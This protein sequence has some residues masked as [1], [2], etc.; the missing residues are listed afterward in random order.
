MHFRPV[1]QYHQSK[2]VSV[3]ITHCSYGYV[4]HSSIRQQPLYSPPSSPISSPLCEPW[5]KMKPRG[6][7]ETSLWT[8][9]GCRQL[10]NRPIMSPHFGK[11]SKS[12]VCSTDNVSNQNCLPAWQLW[13]WERDK[14]GEK[15]MFLLPQ[16]GAEII[17]KWEGIHFCILVLLFWPSNYS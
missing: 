16:Q 5:A 2:P 7:V 1:L 11:Q 10:S 12:N 15:I 8:N 3:W 6:N 13:E 14:E 4:T 9:F 17:L